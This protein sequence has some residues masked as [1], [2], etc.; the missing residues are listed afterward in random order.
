MSDLIGVQFLSPAPSTTQKVQVHRLRGREEIGRSFE[1]RIDLV[2][3]GLGEIDESR[4]LAEP[5]AIELAR[6]DIVERRVFGMVS[7]IRASLDAIG[8]HLEYTLTFVPRLFRTSLTSTS[9]VFL[10]KSI[11]DVIQLK[12]E[13]AGFKLGEDFSSVSSPRTRL[14]TS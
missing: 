6:G 14:A 12:L 2:T 13:R 3:A 10:D 11:P 8:E 9:E 5:A 4:L 1:L 7:A